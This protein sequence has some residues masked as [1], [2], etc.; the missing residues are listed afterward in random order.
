MTVTGIYAWIKNG[1]LKKHTGTFES[2]GIKMED[3]KV[4]WRRIKDGKRT[5]TFC[6]QIRPLVPW[7]T[8]RWFMKMNGGKVLETYPEL[9]VDTEL[10]LKMSY[11][12][13]VQHLKDTFEA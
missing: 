11:E 3:G 4:L 5:N 1:E 9:F 13:Y 6:E 8:G 2:T 10:S 7:A 12:A